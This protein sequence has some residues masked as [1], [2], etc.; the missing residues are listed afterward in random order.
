MRTLL[1]GAGHRHG[2][3]GGRPRKTVWTI[4]AAGRTEPKQ[5][6]WLSPPPRWGEK[7]HF[8]GT[9]P[10]ERVGRRAHPS[11]FLIVPYTANC[12]ASHQ[13]ADVSLARDS[14]VWQGPLCLLRLPAITSKQAE[15][16]TECQGRRPSDTALPSH[17]APSPVP[18]SFC[19]NISV[20]ISVR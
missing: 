1:G 6:S 13:A 12:G 2:G 17:P 7:I 16:E 20:S 8:A 14:R 19:S 11:V 10:A 4:T 15:T 3:V 5:R 18:G 9:L